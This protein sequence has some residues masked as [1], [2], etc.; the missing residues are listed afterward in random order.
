MNKFDLQ[1]NDF[2][3]VRQT[4]S[5]HCIYEES[6]GEQTQDEVKVKK[7]ITRFQSTNIF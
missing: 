7:K 3:N 2:K 6:V 1:H 5:T 4:F